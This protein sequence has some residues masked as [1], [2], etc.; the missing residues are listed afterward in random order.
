LYPRR[1]TLASR[2]PDILVRCWWQGSWTVADGPA[3][4]SVAGAMRHAATALLDS[5]STVDRAAAQFP[6]DDETAR[7]D[8]DFVPKQGRLGI[9]LARLTSYQRGLAHQLLVAGLS[10][11]AYGRVLSV[12]AQENILRELQRDQLGLLA[13]EV[14]NPDNYFI[15]VFGRPNLEATWGW[16]FVGHHVSLNTT[17]VE[18]TYVAATPLV[19]GSEPAT[20]GGVFAPLSDEERLGFQLLDSLDPDQRSATLIHPV[21]PPDLVT[22]VTD[23][24][25]AIEV[26]GE[27]ELGFPRYR[28][29]PADQEALSYRRDTPRGISGAQMSGE[30]RIYLRELLDCYVGRVPSDLARAYGDHDLGTVHFGWAGETR[31]GAPHYYRLQA[32]RLLIEFENVQ[33][34]GDHIHTVWR[35][36][37][38]D[39]GQDLLAE[40]YREEHPG[41][42]PVRLSRLRSSTPDP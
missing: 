6:F 28:I 26:P 5:L 38:G 14:R 12:M 11:P 17:I 3:A 9:P 8:W 19:I 20:W 41:E 24:V 1:A 10:L 29:N 42:L 23:H 18:D 39:F 36:P 31:L 13:G 35:D 34:S 15:C 7:T 40:H 21:A 27:H 32:P 4:P 33:Q 2:A 37:D 16:R 22:R 30:Q 25:G